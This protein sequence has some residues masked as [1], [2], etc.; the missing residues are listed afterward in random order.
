MAQPDLE[1]FIRRG[2][3]VKIQAAEGT[4]EAPNTATDGIRF[5]DGQSGT[6]FDSLEENRDRPFFGGNEFA[7]FNHRAF[8]G[9]SVHL[10]PPETPGDAVDGTPDAD[11][12]LLLGGFTKV[13]VAGPPGVTRYNPVSS[14]FP[15]G[16][17]DFWHA[18]T[19]RRIF[20]ARAAI[21]AL[22]LAIGERARVNLRLLGTYTSI[23]E[24]ALPSITVPETL[25]PVMQAANSITRLEVAG[26]PG[27]FQCWGKSLSI[28][29]GTQ[30]ASKEYTE[31][32]VNAIDGRSPTWS[33][34]VARQAKADFDPWA[35]RKAGTYIEGAQ[36]LIGASDL[37]TEL[38]FRGLIREINEVDIDGDYGW[39]LSGPA[40]PT[41]AGGDECYIE[42]GTHV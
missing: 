23:D 31:K 19:K 5:Y 6:E 17:A 12:L 42:F 32:K 22:S 35:L 15:V 2:V 28:D 11:R 25:G 29:L 39:E 4:A 7:T 40:I 36:R 10:Y 8:I 13:L 33:L 14:G 1:K 27:A 38:G 9:G 16:T 41:S 20:D 24:D 34:R 3:A 37:Y 30:L 21:S 26:G 18:G